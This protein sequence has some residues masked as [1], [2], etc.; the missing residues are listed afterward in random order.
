MCEFFADVYRFN[1]TDKDLCFRRNC[2]TG[3][4][5]DSGS[6]LTYDLC[7]QCAIDKDS[8]SYFL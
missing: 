1:F 8:F 3:H 7:I 4:L 2:N 6:F 5:S